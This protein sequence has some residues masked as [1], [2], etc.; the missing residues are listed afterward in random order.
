MAKSS[1]F[2][3]A[4]SRLRRS[5]KRCFFK[6]QS[7]RCS[8]STILQFLTLSKTPQKL[9]QNYQDWTTK[10]SEV[11]GAN[12]KKRC[13]AGSSASSKAVERFVFRVCIGL[14]LSYTSAEGPDWR[15]RSSYAEQVQ[16]T[17]FHSGLNAYYITPHSQ[18]NLELPIA[19]DCPQTF[20]QS[21]SLN[22]GLKIGNVQC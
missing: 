5:W 22:S 9:A 10:P 14:R 21:R 1:L 3:L 7:K 4:K 12:L 17:G 13:K 6:M 19:I 2:F 8:C 11:N 16:T 20:S 18:L 15:L